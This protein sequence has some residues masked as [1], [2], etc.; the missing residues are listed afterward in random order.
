MGREMVVTDGREEYDYEDILHRIDHW[1]NMAYE[2]LRKKKVL[3]VRK[4]LANTLLELK[5]VEWDLA[6]YI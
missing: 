1:I 3:G 2:S 5:E 6:D 4:M